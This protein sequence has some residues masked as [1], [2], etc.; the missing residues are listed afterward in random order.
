MKWTMIFTFMMAVMFMS[1]FVVNAEVPEAVPLQKD[2]GAIASGG[3]EVLTAIDI[4]DLIQRGSSDADIAKL[5]SGQRGHDR[6]SVLEKGNT[7]DQIIKSP[8]APPTK[9]TIGD[10]E[11]MRHKTEGDIYFNKSQYDKA[12]KE[13]TLAIKYSGDKYEPYQ[14]RANTYKQYLKT[15]W[16][17]LSGSDSDQA[18]QGLSKKSKRFLCNSIYA[19]Y[20]EAL[21]IS[22]RNVSDIVLELNVLKNKMSKQTIIYEKDSKVAAS[23]YRGGQNIHDMRRLE[24]LYQ[25]HRAAQKANKAV[26]K[27]V[28]EAMSDYKLVCEAKEDTKVKEN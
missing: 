26:H 20:S 6:V 3:N 24:K 13:Y 28:N 5:L 9:K 11:S 23:R 7:D 12:A 16:N 18:R 15:K 1:G 14:L 21:K 10:Q 22:D 25:S 8:M 2:K 27:S 4:V 19:D 17:S